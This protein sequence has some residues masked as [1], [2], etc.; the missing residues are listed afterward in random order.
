MVKKVFLNYG[1]PDIEAAIRL[2]KELRS[3][4]LEIWFDE[5]CILPGQRWQDEIRRAILNSDYFVALLSTRSVN[6]RGFVQAEI[7]EALEVCREIPTNQIFIIPARLDDCQIPNFKLT[8]YQW[9]NLYPDW[10]TGV[11]KIIKAITGDPRSQKLHEDATAQ[12]ETH[13]K[14]SQSPRRKHRKIVLKNASNVIVG[15]NNTQIIREGKA[16]D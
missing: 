11:K 14:A 4:G 1:K 13:P 16:N 7:T 6:K 9:V 3:A 12:A 8:E 15:N 2:A 5:D 10:T